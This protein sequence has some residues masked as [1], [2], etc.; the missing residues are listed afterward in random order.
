VTLFLVNAQIALFKLNPREIHEKNV[1]TERSD[2][3]FLKRVEESTNSSNSILW[4]SC[5]SFL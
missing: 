1:L 5:F 2:D 4:E 3:Q